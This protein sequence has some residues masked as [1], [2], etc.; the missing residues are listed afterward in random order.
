MFDVVQRKRALQKLFEELTMKRKTVAICCFLVG[1]AVAVVAQPAK[2]E[3]KVSLRVSALKINVDDMDKGLSFYVE[4]LGFEIADKSGYPTE[5]VL[6]TN[7]TFKLILHRVAHVRGAAPAETQVGLTLQVNDLDQSIVKMKSMNV[8]FGEA[9]P[10]REAVGNAIFIVDPFGM[11]ISLMHETVVK[12]E[13]FKEPRIYNFGV[14]IPDMKRGREFYA[15]KLGF[16]VRSE[17]YLPLDLPLGHSDKIFAFMLHY[18]PGVTSIRSEYPKAA[19]F[20]TM[21]FEATDPSRTVAKLR[22]SGVKVIASGSSKPGKIVVIE[23]P[24]GNVSEIVGPGK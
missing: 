12:N 4:K 14:L 23:D 9:K 3:T 5:V 21:V 1:F 10:R 7:D 11:K 20:I 17:K 8:S 18:R 24:F 16:V 15:D 13:P 22:R 19:P 2:S 6:S